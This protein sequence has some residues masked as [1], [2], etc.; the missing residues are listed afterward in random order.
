MDE[1]AGRTERAEA[2][3]HG[4]RGPSRSAARASAIAAVVTAVSAISGLMTPDRKVTIGS[5]ATAP[6]PTVCTKRRRRP[7]TSPMISH[8]KPMTSHSSG[9]LASRMSRSRA[10]SDQPLPTA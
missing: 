10:G 8:E 6:V 1:D 5:S 4:T 2:E 3:H 9:R 7:N